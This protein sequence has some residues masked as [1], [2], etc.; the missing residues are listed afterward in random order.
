MTE[1]KQRFEA[2]LDRLVYHG[3]NLLNALQ[4]DC[5][6]REFKKALAKRFTKEEADKILSDLPSFR[7]EYQ[8]WYSEAQALVRQVLPDRLQDFSSYYEYS[9]PR[10]SVKFQNYMIKDYLQGLVIR[11]GY[12]DQVLVD[13][14]AAIPE[15]RQQLNIV[16]AAQSVLGSA[17]ANLEKILQADMFDSELDAARDLAKVGHLRSA[18]VLC[19]VVI[20]KHL[21]QVCKDRSIRIRKK[22]PTINDFG[23][24]LKDKGVVDV[25][26]WRRLQHLSDIRNLC[27]HNREQEPTEEHVQE[28]ISGT[29]KVIKTVF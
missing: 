21:G 8:Q 16:E 9:R 5:K 27:S 23:Q 15:F 25:P 4:H 7:D 10:K 11:S 6:E 17:L 26:L 1:K 19:G 2:D 20:E 3:R 29:S 13:G 22:R 28:L 24:A 14:S 18:G 12:L